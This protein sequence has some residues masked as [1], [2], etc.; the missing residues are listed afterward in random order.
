MRKKRLRIS[1]LFYFQPRMAE[2]SKSMTKEV[3]KT[4]NLKVIEQ[5]GYRYQATPTVMLKGKWISEFGFDIGTHVK[6][7][8]EDGRLIITKEEAIEE[9]MPEKNWNLSMDGLMMTENRDTSVYAK[10]LAEKT[11]GES[12]PLKELL[13][14]MVSMLP[15]EDQD[16][17][18]LY[19]TE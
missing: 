10:Q 17:Y 3:K 11:A 18:R 15:E 16:L 2:G 13:N 19:Y 7:E 8:C 4:R 9:I 14:E 1:S 6:V 12:D 5:S